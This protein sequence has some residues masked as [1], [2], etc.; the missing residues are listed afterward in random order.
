MSYFVVE[1]SFVEFISGYRS[2]S[3]AR[4]EGEN[5][6]SPDKRNDEDWVWDQS[7]GDYPYNFRFDVELEALW[8]TS[9]LFHR[10][11]VEPVRMEFAGL[12]DDNPLP[13]D[14]P[15]ADDV[16]C[17]MPER[18]DLLSALTLD[19]ASEQFDFGD[20]GEIQSDFFEEV[21]GLTNEGRSPELVGIS[22]VEAVVATPTE[23]NEDANTGSG[24]AELFL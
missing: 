3:V 12:P 9:Q 15:T 21:G 13:K 8:V 6:F 22:L 14:P 23:L 20:N 24:D 16:I 11:A 7:S 4:G 17:V 10:W 18:N 5:P 2:A 19:P 1:A